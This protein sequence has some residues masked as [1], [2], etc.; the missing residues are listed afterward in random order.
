[1]HPRINSH[2]RYFDRIIN[3]KVGTGKGINLDPR[4]T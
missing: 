2:W 3:N 4:L 1:M